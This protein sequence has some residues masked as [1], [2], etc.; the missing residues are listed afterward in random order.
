MATKVSSHSTG[1][2]FPS[3]YYGHYRS[4]TRTDFVNEYR[5]L[6]KPQPPRRFIHRSSQPV[7]SHLFSTHDNRNSFMCDAS[8]FAQVMT[9][10]A[11]F[12][13]SLA[14]FCLTAVVGLVLEVI[15]VDVAVLVLKIIVANVAVAVLKVIVLDVTVVAL[16]ASP[17]SSSSSAVVVVVVV[18]VMVVVVD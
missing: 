12:N 5:Q 6:A 10:I 4:K 17:S 9:G 2:W 16:V 15:L 13:K 14:L 18:V 7:V 3:G 8:Y 11:V 1:S